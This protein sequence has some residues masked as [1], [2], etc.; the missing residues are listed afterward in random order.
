V[1]LR[2]AVIDEG[3]SYPGKLL[4]MDAGLA[5]GKLEGVPTK[6]PAFGLDAWWIE[7][8]LKQRAENLNYTV[9]DA[10]SVLA[11]HLT[12]VVKRHAD[13]LLSRE[14]VHNLLEGAKERAPKVVGEVIGELV[15]PAELQRVLQNLLR[16]RVPIRDLETIIETLGDWAPKSKDVDV[17]TEYVRHALRR[18]ICEQYAVPGEE[19]KPKLVC[20]TL[21]SQLEDF[22]AS[23]VDRSAAGTV[24]TMPPKLAGVVAS[25]VVEA[26]RPAIAGGYQ[27]LVLASPQVRAPVRELVEPHLSSIAVVGYNEIVSG[28]QIESMGLVQTPEELRGASAA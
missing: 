1:K 15:K 22:I 8:G 13:E 11:T 20:V 5:S 24:V 2:G 12:E 3:V 26:L 23:Y 18:T 19:G 25:A 16:E 4:A 21:D 28:V 17:L 6:E 9:V 10:S 27:P 7:P 14:E